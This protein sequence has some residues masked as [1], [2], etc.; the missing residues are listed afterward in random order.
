MCQHYECRCA[1][2]AELAQMADRAMNL[3]AANDLLL[4]AVGIHSQQV[5]C[6]RPRPT[7]ITS[8]NRKT[9]S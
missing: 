1:R 5:I 6:R 3:R 9:D 4:Q 2:A 7:L 8:S